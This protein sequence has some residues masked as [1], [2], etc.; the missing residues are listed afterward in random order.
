MQ[1]QVREELA[2]TWE[3]RR[4]ETDI[5]IELSCRAHGQCQMRN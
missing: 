3:L 1:P 2:R 5:P 4:V